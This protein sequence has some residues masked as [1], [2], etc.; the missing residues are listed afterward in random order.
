[1]TVTPGSF[2]AAGDEMPGGPVNAGG[3][4]N[5]MI[6]HA[7]VSDEAADYEEQQQQESR[8]EKKVTRS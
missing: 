7:A 6:E 8:E 2:I 1:V 4:D 3:L 5:G